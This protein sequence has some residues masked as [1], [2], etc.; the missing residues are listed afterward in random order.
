MARSIYYQ[1]PI[2]LSRFGTAVNREINN[3]L[4][5]HLVRLAVLLVVGVLVGVVDAFAP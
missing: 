1:L 2:I 5:L 3:T 4:S